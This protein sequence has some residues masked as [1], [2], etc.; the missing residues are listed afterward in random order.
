MIQVLQE[1]A[2]ARRILIVCGPA[3]ID[4]YKFCL[5]LESLQIFYQARP[6]LHSLIR[7]VTY[8]IRQAR[9][10]PTVGV[11]WSDMSFL[12]IHPLGELLDMFHTHEAT[13]RHDKVYALLGMS[14]DALNTANL[15]PD[16]KVPWKEVFQQLIKF[17]L[18]KQVSV[19]TWDDKEVAVIKSQGC[20][21][22]QVSSVEPCSGWGDTQKVCIVSNTSGYIG[23]WSARLILHTSTKSIQQGD[24]V[25]LPR[26]AIKLTIIRICKYYF[27]II[28]I[29]VTPPKYIRMGSNDIKW[30]EILQSVIIFPRK[31]LLIWDWAKFPERPKNQEEYETL[32]EADNLVQKQSKTELEHYWEG[33]AELENMALILKDLGESKEVEERLREVINSY[34]K[35]FG[36]EHIQTL[37]SMANL[38]STYRNQRR[39]KE[40][41]ELDVQVMET[42]ERVLGAGH[43]DT[44][45][46]MAGLASTYRNQGRWKE[47]EELDVQ[48]I[49]TR[50]RALRAAPAYRNQG[51]WKEAE[52]LDVQVI[53][54]SS[55]VLGAEHL[56]TL[57]SIANLASTSRNQERWKEADELDVQ[58]VETSSRVLGAEHPITLTSIANLASTFWNQG[59]WKEAEELFVHAI[60]I[61]KRVLGAEHLDTLTSMANLASTFWNQGRWKEAEELD[62]QVMETRKRVLGAE[63]P[64][65]LTSMNNLAHAWKSQGR[66]NEAISLLA[67]CHELRKKILG[68]RHPFTH[69]S[70]GALN[71]W[72]ME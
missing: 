16:Y 26:G 30:S 31:F 69:F 22:G 20:I 54:T 3:E 70:F 39:W 18:C 41:E 2:A 27:A 43:P 17:L 19:K 14:S 4:G 57:T 13:E 37:I 36:K 35:M 48:V 65:T 47:A 8:L 60:E 45:T 25:Y 7:S 10:R 32:L 5:G 61:R 50:E 67:K 51:R 23:E 15:L 1:V 56:D 9:F 34:E 42:R 12:A 6:D 66:S 29:A 38:A 40:A 53:E 52:E 68:S 64:D 58:V 71:K 11:C 62:V 63:H 49:E 72:R 28:M 46:S 59:R 44:L 21:L 55:R 24:L 33:P